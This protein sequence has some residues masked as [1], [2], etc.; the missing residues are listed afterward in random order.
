MSL[1]LLRNNEATR[2]EAI[3]TRLEAIATSNNRL[4]IYIY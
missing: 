2:L 1:K 3:A 4:Y